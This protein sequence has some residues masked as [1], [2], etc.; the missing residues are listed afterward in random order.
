MYIELLRI[1][2]ADPSTICEDGVREAA[3]CCALTPEEEDMLVAEWKDARLTAMTD[4]E[5]IKI[6]K[7]RLA[8]T[9]ALQHLE[10]MSCQWVGNA[11]YVTMKDKATGRL[12]VH[13]NAHKNP[14][15]RYDT[16]FTP[17]SI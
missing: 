17:A 1:I 9:K 8:T 16:I 4:H 6:V 3:F 13:T 5:F 11:V 14:T 15:H 12:I 7:Q 2:R 10:F